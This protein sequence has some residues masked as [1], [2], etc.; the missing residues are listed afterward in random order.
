MPVQPLKILDGWERP[1]DDEDILESAKKA[2][3]LFSK[4]SRWISCDEE[5]PEEN[6]AVLAWAPRYK[7]IYAL[8]YRDGVWHNFT[9]CA[10]V[11]DEH[12]EDV[13]GK[14][15]HWRQM[16]KPPEERE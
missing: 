8:L 13:Y 12:G 16:P 4:D 10:C 11:P 14:I 7:N 5:M 6:R 9:S 1:S 3:M 15:T 2:G